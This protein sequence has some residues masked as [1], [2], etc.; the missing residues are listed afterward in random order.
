MSNPYAAPTADLSR[1]ESGTETYE[2]A[3]FS[4]TGRI[5][6][7][8]YIAY[9]VAY[10]ALALIPGMLVGAGAAVFGLVKFAP[11]LS[12]LMIWLVPCIAA[13]RRLND[14][15]HNSWLALLVL[16]PYLNMLVALW[17][18]FAKGSEGPNTYGPAPSPNTGGT[19]AAAF[20]V[21]VF[22]VGILA[23]IAIPAYQ[24]YTLRARAAAQN[25]TP[26]P[27]QAPLGR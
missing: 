23:A 13:R 10:G 18:V 9:S 6:R 26:A 5:G 21:P 7:V 22:I 20:L 15:D 8:R 1:L 14:M 27:V 24:S 11:L 17:L 25:S 3:I 19:I 12:L 2:P 16:V 4:L